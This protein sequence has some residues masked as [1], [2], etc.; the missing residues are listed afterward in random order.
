MFVLCMTLTFGD[1][2]VR[3]LHSVAKFRIEPAVVR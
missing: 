1:G 2:L 3:D